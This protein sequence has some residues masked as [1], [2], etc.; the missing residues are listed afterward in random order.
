ML[1]HVINIILYPVKELLKLLVDDRITS[2]LGV[3]PM[4]I[5]VTCMITL[6]V[7]AALVH[8]VNAGTEAAS[9][10]HTK[11]LNRRREEIRSSRSD[12]SN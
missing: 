12:R 7:V 6:I 1:S 10:L 3:S 4:A 2:Y 8:R 5:A 11:D 9:I